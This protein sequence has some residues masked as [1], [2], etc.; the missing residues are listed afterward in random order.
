MVD[1]QRVSRYG[2]LRLDFWRLSSTAWKFMPHLPIKNWVWWK[3]STTAA[4]LI[5][6]FY[7][8]Y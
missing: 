7:I 5:L 4:I 1:M 8:C 2:Q 3:V 6:D